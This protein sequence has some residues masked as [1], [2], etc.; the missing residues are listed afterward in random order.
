MR[1]RRHLS[2]LLI[3][4][5]LAAGAAPSALAQSTVSHQLRLLRHLRIVRSRKNGRHV[6]YQLEDDHVH[7]LFER[8]CAHLSC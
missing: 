6:F 7:D 5:L 2:R 3:A 4:A 1:S 8:A